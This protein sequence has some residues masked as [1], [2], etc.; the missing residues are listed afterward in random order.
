MRKNV[1]V[2][3]A[4][5]ATCMAFSASAEA[6]GAANLVPRSE[7]NKYRLV[8]D[9]NLPN[10]QSHGGWKMSAVPYYVNRAR[11][12]AQGGFSR[13]AYWLE[14]VDKNGV[15]NWVW[16]SLDAFTDDPGKLG[17][18]TRRAGAWFQQKVKN[19]RIWSNNETIVHRD[20]SLVD[21]GNIEFWPNSYGGAVKLGL[22]GASGSLFDFDDTIGGDNYG[23]MQIHDYKAGC[24]LF[25]INNWESGGMQLGVGTNTAGGNPDW[26]GVNTGSLYG[27]T[28]IRLQVYVMDGG[29][30]ATPPEFL[31]AT[32]RRGG[33][34]IVLAFSEP[35]A[36]DQDFAAAIAVSGATVRGFARDADD[37]SKVVAYVVGAVDGS[38]SVTATGV[39]DAAPRRNAMSEPVT[40]TVEGTELPPAIVAHV[41]AAARAGYDLVYEY[42]LPVEG[43]FEN[44][45]TNLAMRR[46]Y[47]RVVARAD[48][49]KA[50]DRM[51]YYMEL[52]SIDG[53]KTNW[54][55]TSFSAFTQD[56]TRLDFPSSAAQSVG[57]RAAESLDVESN[58]VGM[59]TGTGLA[60][61]TVK[62]DFGS[63]NAASTLRVMNGE[64]PV[65]AINNFRSWH[66]WV[67]YG[68]GANTSGTGTT[69]W[70]N[71]GD[72]TVKA[73]RIRRLYA[74][75][76]P[77]ASAPASV[78]DYP[79]PADVLAHVA[80]AAGYALLQDVTID[81]TATNFHDSAN[82]AS[83][84]V[85]DNTA[86]FTGKTF[87]R[88]AYYLRYVQGGE[89][90]WVWT[91]F[92]APSQKL[93]DIRVPDSATQNFASRVANMR[94]R[95]N[96]AGVRTGDG[97]QTG[98]VNFFGACPATGPFLG[99]PNAKASYSTIDYSPNGGN[100]W[101]SFMV[102]DYAV[103]QF[104]LS[105]HGLTYKKNGVAAGIGDNTLGGSNA[106]SWIFN[107]TVSNGL[108]TD[109]RL[110]VFV[111]EGPA[112]AA[113]EYL[114]TIAETGGR[115]VCVLFNS[116]VTDA[117]LDPAAYAV[118]P[119]AAVKSAERSPLD[120]REVV[121]TFAEPLQA[122]VA[123]T[124]SAPGAANGITS[125]PRKT[126][127][128]TFT[129]PD[130]TLPAVLDAANVAEV[131][132]Y[133][134]V[135]KF[136]VP[137]GNSSCGTYGAPYVLDKTRFKG[138]FSFDRVAYALHLVGTDG[139]EKWAWASMDA[140]TGDASQI[141]IPS[142][143]RK[144]GWQC[145][146]TNLVVRHGQTGGTA[147]DL[148]DGDY[149]TGN[150]EFFPGN[151]GGGNGQNIP[152]ATGTF[153]F[154]DTPSNWSGG[155]YCSLQVHSY[156]SGQTVIAVNGLSGG[157]VWNA[158]TP[159]LGIGNRP[160]GEAGY[161]GP[162][163][164][165]WGSF[166]V[167]TFTTRDLYILVRPTA[168]G[169]D[170]A[171]AFAVAPEDVQVMI[172]DPLT[173]VAYAPTA[174]SYQWRKDGEPI[175]GATGTSFDVSAAR[176]GTARYDVVA[177]DANG[178]SSVCPSAR[179]K[180]ISGGT[181]LTIR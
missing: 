30:D 26:T 35:V 13:V 137:A 76:R 57:E 160:S 94:V 164:T 90:K 177:T 110:Y 139:S 119:A 73:T 45:P 62:I 61:G 34:E 117:L 127:N 43:M 67:W 27:Y 87:S 130:E 116:A 165:A 11:Q 65:L 77:V 18:P 144:P 115:R 78:A 143:R 175:A 128:R 133:E 101:G 5:L 47:N 38:V 19:L 59:A 51:A 179:V 114:Y 153:D 99:V 89:E 22:P 50:I 15:H 40:R 54:V 148:T 85:A 33:T 147:I 24:T 112:P 104:I 16:V 7:F 3:T 9:M 123:Y 81:K 46:D 162:D 156:L 64:T 25:G 154:G 70:L 66:S 132:D 103:P 48:Y 10:S 83:H 142:E 98:L 102:C 96:V 60:G 108:F 12:V 173:L 21:E 55:W 80:E 176:P 29:T 170:D 131:G 161:Q 140:F 44:V 88:V 106:P 2:G 171:P 93:A 20:G 49:P 53:T 152:G 36:A 8:Y 74:L 31:S 135:Y 42:D 17:V 124:M 105:V 6:T 28:S 149:A 169:R 166:N 118:H 68:I 157:A 155:Q 120:A 32:T 111:Q 100:N 138:D 178:R 174:V 122:G 95:S 141:G 23:S 129:V 168:A 167:S 151:Y 126:M 82:Y 63:N 113:P 79:A 41:S 134:L 56:V 39:T 107:Y 97:I 52:I 109:A 1:F 75:V 92:D 72:A 37:W 181:V 158:F 86:A 159:N 146:V 91:S 71:V 145:Y 125:E 58:V 180:I 172:H 163:W 69:D 136:A 4:M 14:T 121:L 84:M 150:I